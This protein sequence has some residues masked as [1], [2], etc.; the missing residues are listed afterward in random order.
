MLTTPLRRGVLLGVMV[1][2]SG[3]IALRQTYHI[4]QNQPNPT[5]ESPPT[6]PQAITQWLQNPLSPR[7]PF[8]LYTTVALTTLSTGLALWGGTEWLIL[9]QRMTRH[10]RRQMVES[11]AQSQGIQQLQIDL[12]R[13]TQE[14]NSL[15]QQLNPV[16]QQNLE[17]LQHEM[18][19]LQNILQQLE[20][21]N[22]QVLNQYQEATHQLE[23]I[24]WYNK[25]LEQENHQLHDEKGQLMQELESKK[26]QLWQLDQ[27]VKKFQN[28]EREQEN[29]EALNPV[30]QDSN[31]MPFS[32]LTGISADRALRAVERLG[33]VYVGQRGS[34]IKYQKEQKQT[35]TFIL[36]NESEIP[37]GTLK[38]ALQNAGISLEEFLQNLS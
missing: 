22:K 24:N 36:P 38:N 15:Q 11:R 7:H 12:E 34:H 28:Q 14:R 4:Q 25:E 3:A 32:E 26:A 16:V 8:P 10:L 1:L 9:R 6:F 13:L 21:Q 2:G 35:F 5:A 27:A 19:N 17:I 29:V 31:S 20:Q 33:F 30:A 18:V 23:N 37:P